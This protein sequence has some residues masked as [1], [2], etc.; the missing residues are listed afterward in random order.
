MQE[1]IAMGA[2]IYYKPESGAAKVVDREE[3][4]R[5]VIFALSI[6]KALED[7]QSR[8]FETDIRII[9]LINRADIT[10]VSRLL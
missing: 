6:Q 1:F 3:P 7:F 2:R 8:R 10:K 5:I 4:F 9:A